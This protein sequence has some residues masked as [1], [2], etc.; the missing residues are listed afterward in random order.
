MADDTMRSAVRKG[1]FEVPAVAP[2]VRRLGRDVAGVVVVLGAETGGIE[3]RLMRHA[4]GFVSVRRMGVDDVCVDSLNVSVAAGLVF[5][6]VTR[7]LQD[8][9]EKVEVPTVESIES[10]ETEES[11]ESVEVVDGKDEDRLF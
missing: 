11:V 4:D 6:E 2:I 8:E 7:P 10:V 5:A 3:R 1:R 9:V